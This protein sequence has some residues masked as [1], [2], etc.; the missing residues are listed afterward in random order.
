M[1]L[2]QEQIQQMRFFKDYFP[3]R[4]VFGALRNTKG[5]LKEGHEFVCGAVVTNHKPNKLAR[6]GWTVFKLEANR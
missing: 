6:E 2:S 5:A 3:Y 4:I 1:E